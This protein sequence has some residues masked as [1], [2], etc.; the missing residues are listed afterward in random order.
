[1]NKCGLQPARYR[2]TCTMSDILALKC[3]REHFIGLMGDAP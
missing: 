1:M 2:E 3:I